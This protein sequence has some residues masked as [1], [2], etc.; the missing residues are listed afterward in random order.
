MK[1]TLLNLFAIILAVSKVF[2]M[3]PLSM[4]KAYAEGTAAINGMMYS[5][6]EEY[7]TAALYGL[8]KETREQSTITIPSGIYFEGYYTVTS[9]R[10]GAFDY[11]T[12]LTTVTIPESVTSIEEDA[13]NYCT[14][15][16]TVN[17]GGSKYQWDAITGDGKPTNVTVNFAKEYPASTTVGGV[18]YLLNEN[19]TATVT[20]YTADL[21]AEVI[22]P[23]SIKYENE[24][25]SVKSIK[26]FAFMDCSSLK[27]ITIP[28]GVTNIGN[29]AFW[30]SGL[31]S[32][33]FEEGSKLTT[34]DAGAFAGCQSLG[35]I[36]IP[37]GVT[38]IK[39]NAFYSCNSMETITIPE[40][41]TS[42]G[43]YAFYNCF[44]MTTI[45]IPESVTS[46]GENAFSGC[47]GLTTVNFGGSKSQWDVITGDGKPANVTVNFAKEY[48]A[49]TTING[50]VYVLNE[51]RVAKVEGYT[52][53]LQ[54]EVTILPSVSYKD[55][56]YTV[57]SIGESAFRECNNL[58]SITIPDSVKSIETKAFYV[59]EALETI[60]LP[61][62]II[63]IGINAFTNCGALK[64]IKLPDSLTSIGNYA[65]RWSGLESIIIP[66][67]VTSIGSEAFL[68]SS[69]LTSVE[70]AEGSAI[71][72]IPI[73]L[74][75]GCGKL[76]PI[77]IPEGVKSIGESAFYHCY[78]M[79][80]ITIPESVTSIRNGAFQSVPLT[81]VNFGG[82]KSQWDAIT[83]EGKPNIEGAFDIIFKNEDGTELQFSRVKSGETPSYEGAT[84]TKAADEQHEYVFAG[85]NPEITAV[86]G[87]ATY[88][89][90]YDKAK[91]LISIS[92]AGV[93]L[94]AKSFT[95]N[96]KAQKPAIVK[97]GNWKMAEGTDYTAAWSN[98]SSK[99][100]GT[101]SVAVTGKGKYKDTA[102]AAYQIVPK[103]TT[104]KKPKKA[105]KA[106]T[107][108][109]K[110][111]KA[112]MPKA[113]VSGY[114]IQLA[115]NS[116][117]TAS[118]KTLKVKGYK[119]TS[120]KV[121]KLKGKTKYYVRVRTY[122][123]S[124]GNTY[125]SP[126]SK[127]KTV[128]TK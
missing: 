6:D 65:F 3:A 1:K 104:L 41:V 91:N 42:I 115:T 34:I 101:Y 125:Y 61:D 21:P 46:I 72:T 30:D 111:Q 128:R 24:D 19:G 108:K 117:F 4:E 43:E 87:D 50:V 53:A 18:V 107:V 112:K 90:T 95:Y 118:T 16:T 17:Y 32:V 23:Q 68:G 113:R 56:D 93:A 86:T 82:S 78:S 58:T 114:Q 22:I 74:F 9:I 122:M 11:C 2:T 75:S 106:V 70:F 57:T 59:C 81:A 92:G 71:T 88:T 89:A 14:G 102:K 15:L 54:A 27:N 8:E 10:R 51:D 33:T 67:S 127:V 13:F 105:K 99:N 73:G 97:I 55:E 48:P 98:A 45:T 77:E 96:G 36:T 83:G 120:K 26:D 52:E 69:A 80:T 31:T 84:P 62:S 103:G 123:K 85:W 121:K 7:E 60:K 20:G 66:A 124:G 47:A 94:S 12:N 5:V 119:K 126:W 38:S 39:K 79:T 40:S 64:T 100:V 116:A 49:S 25:F 44:S 63:S 28:E 29:C 37:E 110:K 76:E 109:W 35:A